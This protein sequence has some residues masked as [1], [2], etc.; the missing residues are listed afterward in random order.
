MEDTLAHRLSA[1]VP[2]TS[3][4]SS[5]SSVNVTVPV[6]LAVP[7]SGTRKSSCKTVF[8]PEISVVITGE[9]A[10]PQVLLHPTVIS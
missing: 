9:S 7:P 6:A 5:A 2:R 3:N 8:V 10:H 1:P 4:V